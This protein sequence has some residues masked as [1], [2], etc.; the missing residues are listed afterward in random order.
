MTTL[1]RAITIFGITAITA[2]GVTGCG[3]P[4]SDTAGNSAI[5]GKGG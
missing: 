3:G 2:F 1:R 5:A 4:K